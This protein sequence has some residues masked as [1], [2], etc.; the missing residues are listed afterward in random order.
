MPK[1]SLL[2]ERGIPSADAT[3]LGLAKALICG[4]KSFPDAKLKN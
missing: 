3:S 2:A 4:G 1:I